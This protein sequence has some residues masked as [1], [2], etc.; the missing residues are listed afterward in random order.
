[1]V[2]R[3]GLTAALTLSLLGLGTAAHAAPP[4]DHEV[5]AVVGCADESGTVEV[6]LRGGVGFVLDESGEPTG[7][8]LF[9]VQVDFAVFS[10]EGVLLEEF[11]KTYGNRTGHGD[12]IFCTG[13]VDL[14]DATGF[15]DAQ[16]TRR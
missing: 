10:D 5:V 4:P 14:G 6:L 13:T 2:Q 3:F 12:P 15:F 11:H 7:E 16:V 9:P 8:K 1:M